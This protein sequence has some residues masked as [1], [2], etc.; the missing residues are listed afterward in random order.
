[1][2]GAEENETSALDVIDY[3]SDDSVVSVACRNNFGRPFPGFICPLMKILSS[4]YFMWRRKIPLERTCEKLIDL[5][6][7]PCDHRTSSCVIISLPNSHV[8]FGCVDDHV[9]FICLPQYTG[10]FVAPQNWYITNSTHDSKYIFDF[11]IRDPLRLT[12]KCRVLNTTGRPI[13]MRNNV[14]YRWTPLVQ[15]VT[16]CCKGDFCADV[17]FDQVVFIFP[18]QPRIFNFTSRQSKSS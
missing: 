13:C 14:F 9:S 2:D 5:N 11:K 17:L 8:L 7:H 12:Q 4:E 10:Q 15:Q 16:C 18:S 6:A 3:N 1:M